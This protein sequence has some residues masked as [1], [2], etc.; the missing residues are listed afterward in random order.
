MV[1]NPGAG[2]QVSQTP[3]TQRALWTF[4]MIMLVAPFFAGLATVA[5]YL[6]GRLAGLGAV[7]TDPL[8]L[9]ALKAYV[10][11]AIPAALAAAGLVVL[12]LRRGTFGWVEAGAAGVIGFALAH[13]AAPLPLGSFAPYAAFGFG[14][15]MIAVRHILAGRILL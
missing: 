2:G 14:V 11:A 6:F 13:A 8:G 4:L 12:V 1:A 9:L 7:P 3:N 10:W 15:V 5:A